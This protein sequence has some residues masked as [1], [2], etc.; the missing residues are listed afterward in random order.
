MANRRVILANILAII[1]IIS[2]SVGCVEDDKKTNGENEIPSNI[3]TVK[4]GEYQ[5]NF[6]LDEIE[7]LESYSGT[8]GY[9][10]STGNISDILEYMGVK[11]T[12]LL[13]EI[14]NLSQNYN[15][16]VISNDGWT[17]NFTKNQTMGYVEVYN[18]TGVILENE[19]AVMILAYKQ[20]GSYYSEIDP[21][22]ETGPLRIA[23]VD[24]GVITSS[25]L[26][27]RMVVSIEIIS[28]E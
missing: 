11:I 28:V 22:S 2:L 7:M 15:I 19:T 8:G 21:N 5:V 23:F 12:T 25:K 3:L 24:N 18:E 27:S 17:V 14:P 20:E 6:T 1:L 10:K 4:F 9:K 16:S 13:Y 26:W